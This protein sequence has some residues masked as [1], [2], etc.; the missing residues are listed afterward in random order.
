MLKMVTFPFEKVLAKDLW[1]IFVA[2]ARSFSSRWLNLVFNHGVLGLWINLV[3]DT[4]ISTFTPLVWLPELGFSRKSNTLVSCPCI[5]SL[6]RP[7]YYSAPKISE[8]M[9]YDYRC[10]SLLLFHSRCAHP[11]FGSKCFTCPLF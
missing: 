1:Y 6:G 9:Y 3:W 10:V 7:C 8:P 11:N 4:K 2:M 5:F